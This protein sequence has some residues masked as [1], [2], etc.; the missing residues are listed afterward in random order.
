VRDVPNYLAIGQGAEIMTLA[1]LPFIHRSLGTKKT[2]AVGII[3]WGARYGAYILGQP[4][5]LV[6]MAQALHGACFGFV[7]VMAMV[8]VDMIAPS[9]ARASAQSF[10][11]FVTYGAG[12]FI[13]SL[14]ISQ[15]SKLCALPGNGLDYKALFMYPF[16]A[17][18]V[19]LAI[20]LFF[21]YPKENNW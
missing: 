5:W 3:C 14:V 16:F 19:I 17:S 6:L 4:F 18:I 20:F 8:Y 10:L 13:S 1:I 12:M 2:I 15:I 9:D 7:F 11:S 21:F